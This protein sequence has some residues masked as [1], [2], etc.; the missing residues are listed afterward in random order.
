MGNSKTNESR[1]EIIMLGWLYRTFIGSFCI[2]TW[3]EI[4]VEDMI[5]EDNSRIGFRYHLQ[6]QKCGHIKF[7]KSY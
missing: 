6:C 2:H 3:K 5:R 7:V 4:F 1:K